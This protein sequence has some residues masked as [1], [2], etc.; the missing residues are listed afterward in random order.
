M[1][2]CGHDHHFSYFQTYA[3]CLLKCQNAAY[4]GSSIAAQPTPAVQLCHMQLYAQAQDM[5]VKDLAQMS[6]LQSCFYLIPY[7]SAPSSQQ[8]SLG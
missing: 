3:V 2:S 1:H 5:N 4:V 7:L 8:A 6:P